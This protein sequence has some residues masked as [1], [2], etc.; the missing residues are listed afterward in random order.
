M[1][2]DGTRHIPVCSWK[3]LTVLNTEN[4]G[5]GTV[6][7]VKLTLLTPNDVPPGV[8]D[9]GVS[10][11]INSVVLV[12]RYVFKLTVDALFDNDVHSIRATVPSSYSVGGAT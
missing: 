12:P 10:G 11:V 2:H 6:T 5:G 3:T 8:A 4:V 9:P 1:H 7:G